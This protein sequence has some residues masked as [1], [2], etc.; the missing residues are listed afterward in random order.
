[1]LSLDLLRET[2]CSLTET[3]YLACSNDTI[4]QLMPTTIN[5]KQKIADILWIGTI[6][7][8]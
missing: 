3:V 8:W 6:L 4:L 7:S 1:M 5:S 2:F